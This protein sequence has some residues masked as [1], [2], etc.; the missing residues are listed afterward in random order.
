M[1]G[2]VR[3][4]DDNWNDAIRHVL[5]P[6]EALRSLLLIPADERNIQTFIQKYLVVDANGGE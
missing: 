4:W 5:Y 2:K 6:D 3:T 1:A